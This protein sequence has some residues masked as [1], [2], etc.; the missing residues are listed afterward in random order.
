M[1]RLFLLV[2]LLFLIATLM[3]PTF[4]YTVSVTD[5]LGAMGD[6]DR[7]TDS[8]NTDVRDVNFY[9]WTQL[10]GSK[11]SYPSNSAVRAKFGIESSEAA[12]VLVVRV[13]GRS[14]DYYYDMY[15]FGEADEMFSDAD[16]DRILDDKGVY[17]ALKRGNVQ[18]GAPRFFSLCAEVIAGHYAELDH[19]KEMK[20][21]WTVVF[22]VVTGVIVGGGSVL[23]VV[24]FYRKKQHG[25]TYPLDRYAKLSLTHS[26][27]RFVG[28]FVTRTRVQS[29]S[30]SGGGSGG[31]GGGGRRGGR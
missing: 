18:E 20:P 28:S 8:G 1:K 15:C 9:L 14:A 17:T 5:E 30:S 24:L 27:D 25:V 29:S 12:V 11:D 31:G 2:S 22:G 16:V 4:A 3:L 21:L 7:I 13:V 19:A 23:G 10:T 6:A 26:E